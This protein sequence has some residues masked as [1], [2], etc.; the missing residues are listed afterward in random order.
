V[1]LVKSPNGDDTPRILTAT[2]HDNPISQDYYPR[3]SAS[4]GGAISAV[5]HI[6]GK[7]V[8]FLLHYAVAF[9]GA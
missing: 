7:A 1:W 9:A 3:L 6:A 4:G 8:E 5:P 2:G